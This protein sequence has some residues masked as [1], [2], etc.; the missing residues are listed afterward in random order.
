MRMLG[1]QSAVLMP[2]VVSFY[3]QDGRFSGLPRS[4]QLVSHGMVLCIQQA[5]THKV[6]AQAQA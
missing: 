5:G 3:K 1:G 6:A 4:T 2:E